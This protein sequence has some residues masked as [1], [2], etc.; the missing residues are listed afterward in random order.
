LGSSI[1]IVSMEQVDEPPLARRM[2]IWLHLMTCRHCRGF[3]RQLL[4]IGRVARLIAGDFEREPTSGFEDRILDRPGG[5]V[6]DT[7][8]LRIA[9]DSAIR[10]LVDSPCGI[11][12]A[13]EVQL[14]GWSIDYFRS[15][16]A[17]LA[18]R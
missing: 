4:R 9:S 6:L 5:T 11:W 13:S 10:F 12:C 16:G 17:P 2:G 14:A 15:G 18:A 8:A 1:T 7:A 3:R